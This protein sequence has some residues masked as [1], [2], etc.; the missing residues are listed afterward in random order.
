MPPSLQVL[1]Q[2]SPELAWQRVDARPDRTAVVEALLRLPTAAP[3]P[4]AADPDAGGWLEVQLAVSYRTAFVPVSDHAPDASRGVELPPAIA[5]LLPPACAN[6]S[7]TTRG[8][9]NSSSRGSGRNDGSGAE[10][11]AVATPLLLRLQSSC[12]AWQ[13]YSSSGGGTLV[14]LPLPDFSMTFNV[15][16]FTSAL[17]A[18]L[19]GGVANLVLRWD[20]GRAGEAAAACWLLGLV[21]APLQGTC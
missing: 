14:P 7:S 15:V 21:Q 3:A 11:T 6:P 20:V 17:L 13:Q 10:C 16:C 4:A 5:T 8:S 2:H 12:G 18:V 1:Q 9:G 19:L